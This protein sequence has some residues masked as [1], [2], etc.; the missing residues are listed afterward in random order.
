MTECKYESR[1]QVEECP[2]IPDCRIYKLYEVD[3]KL[4]DEINRTTLYINELEK[5]IKEITSRFEDVVIFE[6]RGKKK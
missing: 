3:E 2:D 1:C 6:K 5:G 4:G